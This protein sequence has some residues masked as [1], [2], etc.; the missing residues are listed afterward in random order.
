MNLIAAFLVFGLFLAAVA[1]PT[2]GIWSF[3]ILGQ[4]LSAWFHAWRVVKSPQNPLIPSYADY[5]SRYNVI[6]LIRFFVGT[7][8]FIMVA[9][10]GAAVA[11]LFPDAFPSEGAAA[12]ITSNIAIRIGGAGMFGFLADRAVK[13]FFAR[14]DGLKDALPDVGSDD[15]ADAA[16]GGQ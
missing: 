9:F 10:G 16:K 14:F 12:V 3:F 1:L 5:W 8:L 4:G 15:K 11:I 13:K 2:V 7:C 6:V